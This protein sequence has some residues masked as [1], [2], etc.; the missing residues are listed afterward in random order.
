MLKHTKTISYIY[1]ALLF[2]CG[3]MIQDVTGQVNNLV[4]LPSRK[5]QSQD[6]DIYF[7]EGV[8]SSDPGTSERK[9]EIYSRRL[10]LMSETPIF[11]ANNPPT[12]VY[13][14]LWGRS[15]HSPIMIRVQKSGNNYSLV[16]KKAKKQDSDIIIEKE[17]ERTITSKE[18][19]TF[20]NHLNKLS[21]WNYSSFNDKVCLDGATWMLEG[22][23][24]KKYHMV[25]RHCPKSQKLRN[26]CLYLVK[27][28]GL[29][30]DPQEI[31]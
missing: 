17:E 9:A 22:S 26:A 30:L 2:L 10:K 5:I 25:H 29:K 27:L 12:E 21:F 7:P 13:R 8:F 14:F 4:V 20:I 6:T 24:N 15:F 28:S 16:L 19:N 3:L 18:W 31:Y 23:R 1:I 11:A